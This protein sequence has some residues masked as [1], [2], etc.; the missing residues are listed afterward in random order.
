VEEALAGLGAQPGAAVTIGAVTF[1]WEPSTP[2]GIAL[3]MHQRGSDPRLAE[4]HRITA[5]E[6]KAA[7]RARRTPTAADTE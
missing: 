7:K 3:L 6:R 5:T 2:A 4:S 1:D